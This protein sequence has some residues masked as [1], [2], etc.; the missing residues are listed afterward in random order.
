MFV[1]N[2]E[3]IE[4]RNMMLDFIKNESGKWEKGN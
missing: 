1:N 3:D 2:G 4:R